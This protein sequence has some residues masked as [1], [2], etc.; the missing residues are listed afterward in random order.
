MKGDIIML[1]RS[2]IIPTLYNGGIRLKKNMFDSCILDYPENNK[3]EWVETLEGVVLK[4]GT[5]YQK[6][7]KIGEIIDFDDDNIKVTLEHN[8]GYGKSTKFFK[9]NRN[10]LA[11]A[12][13][14]SGVDSK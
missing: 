6:G 4:L 9:I 11:A 1:F 8:T 13:K 2:D 10:G 3:Y 12:H 7:W 14:L 5:F